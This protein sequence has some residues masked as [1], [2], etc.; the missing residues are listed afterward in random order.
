MNTDGELVAEPRERLVE[1]LLEDALRSVSDEQPAAAPPRSRSFWLA[2]AIALLGVGVVIGVVAL[3]K[4]EASPVAPAQDPQ[5]QGHSWNVHAV[6]V[7]SQADWDAVLPHVTGV[8]CRLLRPV[9]GGC[10]VEE[11]QEANAYLS[12]SEA[13]AFARLVPPI[14]TQAFDSERA[15]SPRFDAWIGIEIEGRRVQAFVRLYDQPTLA[16]GSRR[17]EALGDAW[18]QAVAKLVVQSGHSLEISRGAVQSLGELEGVP[19]TTKAIRCPPMPNGTLAKHLGRFTQLEHLE[20][21]F[22]TNLGRS[23]IAIQ[24]PDSPTTLFEEMKALPRLRHL[25]VMSGMLADER[26]AEISRLP[27]LVSLRIDGRLS[28]CD[29]GVLGG[30]VVV[31]GG[32]TAAG[33]RTLAKKIESLELVDAS[34]TPEMLEP[35]LEAA[36]LRK[37]VIF[38]D[39]LPPELLARFARLPT[40]R[41]LGFG[42]VAWTDE[43]LQA[44]AGSRVEILRLEYTKATSTGVRQLPRSLRL[45]DLRK[46]KFEESG[47]R[48]LENGLAECRVLRAGDSDPSDSDPFAGIAGGTRR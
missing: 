46:Q 20:F 1:V 21:A 16:I 3:R 6:P 8:F 25:R 11:I 24:I 17:T 5:P 44:L 33:M 23:P 27:N 48:P 32:I 42:G 41:E 39:A 43:H 34:P 2:A 37:L 28:S 10:G 22:T 40:L 15:E 31:R 30:K 9:A 14:G 38:G 12:G 26:A 19:S 29:A 47:W 18:Q 7:T 45:L 13:S 35:W 4:G 36:Q